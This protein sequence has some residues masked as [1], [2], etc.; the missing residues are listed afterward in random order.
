MDITQD[1]QLI[2]ITLKQD[3]TLKIG[4]TVSLHLKQVIGQRVNFAC[5]AP[6]EI[7]L[8]RAEVAE[9]MRNKNK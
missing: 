4:D 6:K 3:E 2:E 8:Y 9:F 7:S 1:R 5:Y